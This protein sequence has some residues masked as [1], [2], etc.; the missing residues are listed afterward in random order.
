MQKVFAFPYLRVDKRYH[1][2]DLRLLKSSLPDQYKYQASVV[3][4]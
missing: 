3:C 4:Y 2:P 1:R